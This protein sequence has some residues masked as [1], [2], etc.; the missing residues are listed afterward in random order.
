MSS[1]VLAGSAGCAARA[2]GTPPSPAPA[3][4]PAP[5]PAAAPAAAAS[6]AAGVFTAAQANRGQAT[7]KMACS[8]CHLDDLTGSDQAPPLAGDLFVS[9]WT[10][11]KVG[12]LVDRV[13]NTMPL[14]N[15]GSLGTAAATDIVAFMLQ[16]NRF[17]AGAQD[18]TSESFR[19]ATIAR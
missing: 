4:A 3:A 14:D 16:A 5:A 9:N 11:L 7:Y 19:T 6:T 12:D 2:A 10:G 15:P 13:R 18:L 1:A 17:P 8:A